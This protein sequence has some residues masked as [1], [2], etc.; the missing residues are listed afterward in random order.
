MV[1]CR[2]GT[3]RKTPPLRA[4]CMERTAG[5]ERRKKKGEG[6]QQ[7]ADGKGLSVEIIIWIMVT[8]LLSLA[9][10]GPKGALNHIV[11]RAGGSSE[12]LLGPCCPTIRPP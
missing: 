8:V 5:H 6:H 1:R 2:V 7:R 10:Y 11:Q 9:S 12:P 4:K 3:E